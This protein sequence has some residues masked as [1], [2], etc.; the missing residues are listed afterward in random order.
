MVVPQS[1]IAAMQSY[2]EAV[3]SYIATMLNDNA[4]VP[5]G[6][7]AMPVDLAA[8]SGG[9]AGNAD[10]GE[11]KTAEHTEHTEGET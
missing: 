4:T 5:R 10:G 9:P 11:V 7:V 6:C 2:M 1:C 3:Q 8:K